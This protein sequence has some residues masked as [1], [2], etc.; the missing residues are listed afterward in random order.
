MHH[1]GNEY[2]LQVL[3]DAENRWDESNSLKQILNYV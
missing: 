2:L 3:Q 1:S